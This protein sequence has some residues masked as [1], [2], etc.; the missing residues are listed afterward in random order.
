MGKRGSDVEEIA[1]SKGNSG[2]AETKGDD[3][4]GK[5]RQIGPKEGNCVYN[6]DRAGLKMEIPGQMSDTALQVYLAEYNEHVHNI[7]DRVQLEQS[8]LNYS[9]VIMAA[10]IPGSIQI[11]DHHAFAAFFFVPP[12]FM[13]LAVLALRQDLLIT[14]IAGYIDSNLAPQLRRAA[15][16]ESLF[17]LEDTL[18]SLREAVRYAI[19]GVARYA[20]FAFPSVSAIAA[21]PYLKWKYNYAWTKADSVSA[22][23]DVLALVVTGCW[24]AATSTSAFLRMRRRIVFHRGQH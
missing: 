6:P 19:V 4:N 10:L 9:A 8:I 23:V 12:I 20:L 18:L 22:S 11:V 21:V 5:T 1:S 14:A 24:I 3:R 17:R 13:V 2:L 15:S 16:D 7:R